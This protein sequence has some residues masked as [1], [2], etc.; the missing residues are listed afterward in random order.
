M[1]WYQNRPLYIATLLALAFWVYVVFQEEFQ[2]VIV[3]PLQV[4]SM[5]G[6]A[7]EEYLPPTI[8]V[9]IAGTGWNLINLLYLNPNQNCKVN[10]REFS[11]RNSVYYLGSMDLQ[12]NISG[13]SKTKVRRLYP[14]SLKIRV[15]EIVTKEVPVVLKCVINPA[16]GLVED[17]VHFEPQMVQISGSP[18]VLAKINQWNTQRV[19][20]DGVA[21]NFVYQV[22][23]SDSLSNILSVKPNVITVYGSV[24]Q[25]AE[26]TFDDIPLVV[27]GGTLPQNVVV[28]PQ[29][30][31]VTVK[32]SI[33][34][35]RSISVSDIKAEIDYDTIIDNM[36]GYIVPKIS[37]PDYV[38]IL[39]IKPNYVIC[40]N[41]EIRQ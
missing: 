23:M 3:V 26:K 21:D 35:I 6:T 31:T 10:L 33:S 15:G 8:S 32:G 37:C 38:S 41:R 30:L 2:T 36:T 4:N 16:K 24:Q 39:N 22:P 9:D 1:K 40:K 7:I 18:K 34:A 29:I 25:Y 5:A 14:D 19:S 27:K 20:F 12:R 28:L 13:L 11:E 17:K